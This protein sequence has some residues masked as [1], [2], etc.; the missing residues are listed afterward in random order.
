MQDRF[1]RLG[2]VARLTAASAAS[3]V[4]RPTWLA[5]LPDPASA[6]TQTRVSRA[7]PFFAAVGI[8]GVLTV[9]QSI[10]P[11]PPEP[12]PPQTATTVTDGGRSSVSG[13]TEPITVTLEATAA[14]IGVDATAL[15]SLLT[16]EPA[17]SA[18]PLAPVPTLSRYVVQ[19]GDT[20][21]AI[22]ARHGISPQ[23]IAWVNQLANPNIIQPGQV[24]QILSVDGTIHR[25]REGDTVVSIAQAYGISGDELIAANQ[26]EN[27]FAVRPSEILLVPNATRQ[28]SEAPA[29]PRS[30][31][32]AGGSE[33][34]FIAGLAAPAQESQR[35][36]GVPASVTIAQAILETYWGT[37]YLAREANNY[38]GIKAHRRGGTDGVV[39]IDAWE[40][41]DGK[42]VTRQEPFRKYKNVTDSLIDH[43]RFFHENTRYAHALEAR[44][45]AREFARRINAAGYATDPAYAVKLIALM[46]RYGLFQY[47]VM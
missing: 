27:P 46:E 43:G 47:D 35:V 1:R 21:N 32:P 23:T 17:E 6:P 7:S 38:F 28:Q 37:S 13:L 3:R 44:S 12:V 20:V 19:L 45:D 11:R 36:T 41:E 42:S 4:A 33:Q 9:G 10:M 15:T 14:A 5:L 8:V 29:P 40:V 22:A 34:A 16:P 31:E 24:L 18:P 25:T 2:I 39:W 30:R 26:L